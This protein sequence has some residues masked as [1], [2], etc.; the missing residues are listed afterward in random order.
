MTTMTLD[1]SFQERGSTESTDHWKVFP[2]QVGDLLTSRSLCKILKR[3]DLRFPGP[4]RARKHLPGALMLPF[5]AWAEP[6]G[7]LCRNRPMGWPPP[8]ARTTA[9]GA[10]EAGPGPRGRGPGGAYISGGAP[11]GGGAWGSEAARRA[12]RRPRGPRPGGASERRCRGSDSLA[13]ETYGPKPCKCVL[14]RVFSARVARE[15]SVGEGGIGR[16]H[17]P[18]ADL[19]PGSLL[20]PLSRGLGSA[21]ATPPWGVAQVSRSPATPPSSAPGS[22]PP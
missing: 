6:L 14:R 10:R 21:A 2:E 22:G 17:T 4:L 20:A 13:G 5:E 16:S 1:L 15:I 19:H 7:A 11:R 18:L 8:V 12:G 9:G 3:Q